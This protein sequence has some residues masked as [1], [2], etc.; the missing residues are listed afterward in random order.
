MIEEGNWSQSSQRTKS[1]E[2]STTRDPKK[3]E[4]VEWVGTLWTGIGWKK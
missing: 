2:T 4:K 3:V 1:L